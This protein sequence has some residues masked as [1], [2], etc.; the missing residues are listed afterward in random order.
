MSIFLRK[1]WL[2]I[3]DHKLISY[4]KIVM[5][6]AYVHVNKESEEDKVRIQKEMELGSLYSMLDMVIVNTVPLKII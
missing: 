1:K 2:V 5:D 3:E 6:P 4:A